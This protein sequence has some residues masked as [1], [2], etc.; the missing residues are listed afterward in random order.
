[1]R[2]DAIRNARVRPG[3][4]ECDNCDLQMREN[5]KPKLFDVDHCNPAS[6]ASSAITSWDDWIARLF[7]PA[8]E[9]QVLCKVC[10]KT[11]TLSENVKRKKRVRRKRVKGGIT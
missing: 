8:S 3:I 6:E 4:L 9:L 1:M 7:C 11:K 10:H 2:R 5:A